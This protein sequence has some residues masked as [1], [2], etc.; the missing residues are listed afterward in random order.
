M[1]DSTL[2]QF[3][4]TGTT[5]ERLAFTPTPPTPPSGPDPGYTWFDTDDSTLYAYDFGAA[6]WAPAVTGGAGT[7]TNTGTLTANALILG[8]GGVDVAPMASLGTTTTV[9]HG[10]AAGAPTFGAV[11][12]TADVSGTLPVGNGGTGQTSYTD[13]Q[14]LIGNSS[15]NTLTKATLTAGSG[16]SVTNGGGSIT[17]A[18]SGGSGKV[19]QVVNTQTGAVATGSTYIPDD[20]SIPQ[21]TEGDQYMSLA[22]TPTNA[23]NI[24]KIDVVFNGGCS[25]ATRWTTVALFQDSGANALAAGRE[26]NSVATAFATV[27]FSHYMTAGTTSATTFKVRAGG[28]INGASSM[29]F[30]GQGGSRKLGGVLASS[31]T[32]TELAP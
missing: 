14:L 16:I 22:I 18:A 10:N 24:L 25:E 21:N 31:I 7:V 30:N 12:L 27:A 8:N 2:N 20:D 11:S 13:G 28:D 32:I 6:A 1:A 5:A 29:T 23:S 4:A 19:V 26:Y 17:I 15:G 9:L 3:V